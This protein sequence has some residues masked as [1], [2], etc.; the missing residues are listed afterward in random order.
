[1]LLNVQHGEPP[2]SFQTVCILLTQLCLPNIAVEYFAIDLIMDSNGACRGLM[3]LCMEDG[4]IHRFQSH[5]T[6]MATGGY[7]RAYFSATSAHT[8]TGEHYPW[9]RCYH[10]ACVAVRNTIQAWLVDV[11]SRCCILQQRQTNLVLGNTP[12][13]RL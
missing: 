8:C 11:A 13:F 3:A 12:V 6:I 9:S 4:T 7:G 1:M 2:T 10:D 5:N